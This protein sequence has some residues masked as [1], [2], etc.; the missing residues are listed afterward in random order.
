MPVTLLGIVMEVR[1]QPEKASYPMH[2][3]LSGIVAE[4]RFVHPEK[5]FQ[6]ILLTLLGIITEVKL[7]QLSK[8][9]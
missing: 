1:A 3:T 8:A 4:V 7:Q 2:V 6:S 9:E 5:T